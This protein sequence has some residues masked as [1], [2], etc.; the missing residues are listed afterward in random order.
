MKG[1]VI[2]IYLWLVE[3][4]CWF[5]AGFSLKI[6]GIVQR[7][8]QKRILCK[9]SYNP[10]KMSYNPCK[11]RLIA[12]KTWGCRRMARASDRRMAGG[13]WGMGVQ[14]TIFGVAKTFWGGSKT[15]ANI[16]GP[17]NWG[18]GSILDTQ[19]DESPKWNS[20]LL[21]IIILFLN[22]LLCH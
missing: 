2:C 10:H 14:Q 21:N 11:I 9:M 5:K 16:L 15:L 3:L 6:V 12:W 22:G 4:P 1:V 19:D 20:S 7:K 17:K 18:R 13:G 8:R